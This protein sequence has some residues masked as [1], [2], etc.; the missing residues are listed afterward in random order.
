MEKVGFPLT[1]KE[2]AELVAKYMPVVKRIAAGL[3]RRSTD[4]FEDLVQVGSI[5]LLEAIDRYEDGHNAEFKTYAVHLITGH[6]RH[7]LRDRQNLLRG[8]RCLQELSYRLSQVT[9]RFIQ[10]HGREPTLLELSES[11]S[12]T[13]E[14]VDEAR[15][16]D[17]RVTVLWLDQEQREGED[18]EH[19]LMDTL[20]DPRSLEV[21]DDRLLVSEAIDKLPGLQGTILRLRYYQD[22]TQAEIAQELGISQMEVY[23]R[24]KQA[25]K[26][27]K[28]LLNQVKKN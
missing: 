23:R 19:S 5:G 6:I 20:P 10:E 14:Q 17:R 16:Y 24:L 28:A 22:M 3:A 7:Y 21:L 1:P 13:P 4:P 15:M 18:E 25:E 9:S 27:L 2:K 26:H 8:P 12:I 11:L